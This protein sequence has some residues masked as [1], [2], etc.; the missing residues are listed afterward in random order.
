MPPLSRRL[1]TA[2]ITLIALSLAAAGLTLPGLPPA[3]TGA[4]ILLLTLFKA[5]VILADYLDLRPA[6]DWLRGFMLALGTLVI[7]LFGLSLA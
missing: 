2:W 7:L 4:L 5:R 3:L 6:P 1:R